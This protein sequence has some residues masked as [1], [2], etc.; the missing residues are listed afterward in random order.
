MS[1]R[2]LVWGYKG[3]M[4]HVARI[5]C[6]A[7][8]IAAVG[9]RLDELLPSPDQLSDRCTVARVAAGVTTPPPLTAEEALLAEMEELVAE[10]GAEW[11]IEA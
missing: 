6:S 4:A 2:L 9:A 3:N 5:P 1:L 11:V 7:H 8:A 10:G